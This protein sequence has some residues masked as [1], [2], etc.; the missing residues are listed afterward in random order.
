M[1][2]KHTTYSLGVKLLEDDDMFVL[3]Y[4]RSWV[5]FGYYKTTYPGLLEAI[6]AL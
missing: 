5:L 1:L 2:Y 4:F 3:R 6:L